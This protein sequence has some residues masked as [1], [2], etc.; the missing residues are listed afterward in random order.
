MQNQVPMQDLLSIAMYDLQNFLTSD[1]VLTADMR[2][3]VALDRAPLP[4]S[5]VALMRAPTR[6]PVG[7]LPPETH[8]SVGRCCG[9]ERIDY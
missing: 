1:P 4:G 9:L 6:D 3:A 2:R 5:G 7:T 8:P